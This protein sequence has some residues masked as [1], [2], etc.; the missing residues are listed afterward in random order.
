[1]YQEQLELLKAQ[2][3]ANNVTKTKKKKEGEA[4]EPNIPKLLKDVDV[5][6]RD[7]YSLIGDVPEGKETMDILEDIEILLFEYRKVIELCFN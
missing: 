5:Q 3:Q 2:S 4:E 7:V 1:M 6:I